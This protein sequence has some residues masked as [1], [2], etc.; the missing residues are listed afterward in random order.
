MQGPLNQER[1][2]IVPRTR[3]R[4]AKEPRPV[5]AGCPMEDKDEAQIILIRDGDTIQ[6]IEVICT[7]GKKTRL[8]CIF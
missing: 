5:G 8:N 2:G 3:V 6:A 4:V 1:H 7:C